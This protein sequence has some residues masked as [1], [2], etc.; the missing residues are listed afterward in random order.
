[1]LRQGGSE[2]EATCAL[3]DASRQQGRSAAA[4]AEI[5]VQ[6]KVPPKI[7]RTKDIFGVFDIPEPAHPTGVAG[8]VRPT[9]GSRGRN[10]RKSPREACPTTDLHPKTDPLGVFVQDVP[11]EKQA[12]PQADRGGVFQHE[13]L[14]QAPP[15]AVGDA[16]QVHPK[17]NAPNAQP[18]ADPLGVFPRDRDGLAHLRGGVISNMGLDEPEDAVGHSSEDPLDAGLAAFLQGDDLALWEL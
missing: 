12:R 14:W 11:H 5:E 6:A 2:E 3:G 8:Q 18:K 1:M 4:Q 13:I 7:D 15:M 9:S 10:R 17:T 16:R